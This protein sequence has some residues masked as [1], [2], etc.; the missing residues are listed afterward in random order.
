MF[1]VF[2]ISCSV[3]KEQESESFVENRE[4][5]RPIVISYKAIPDTTLLRSCF[6]SDP[7]IIMLRS[8]RVLDGKICTTITFDEACIMGISESSYRK[9]VPKY[10]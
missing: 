3:I 10:E 8:L 2:C 5:L 1:L 7:E 4:D 9:F 6:Q